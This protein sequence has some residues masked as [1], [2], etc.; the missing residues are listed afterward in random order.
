MH[1]RSVRF[2][3]VGLSPPP[4]DPARGDV[5]FRRPRDARPAPH[6][7]RS[8]SLRSRYEM[9]RPQVDV[10]FDDAHRASGPLLTI[11]PVFGGA[12]NRSGR[13]SRAVALST[14]CTVELQTPLPPLSRRGLWTSQFPRRQDR[15]M[16]LPRQKRAPGEAAQGGFRRRVPE[17]MPLARQCRSDPPPV[18]RLCHRGPASDACSLTDA[19]A[20]LN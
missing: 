4:T 7:S 12:E 17:R 14:A 13:F 3:S 9:E 18:P 8:A 19:R 1:S 10:R 16:K 20:W 11:S 2:P 5:S 6:H 15:F